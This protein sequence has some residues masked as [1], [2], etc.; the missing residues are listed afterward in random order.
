MFDTSFDV[1]I[2]VNI[3]I[4]KA[5]KGVIPLSNAFRKPRFC[6]HSARGYDL[7]D[8]GIPY[9]CDQIQGYALFY[10]RAQGI[11]YVTL[12]LLLSI[13]TAIGYD[14]N[15]VIFNKLNIKQQLI[16]QIARDKHLIPCT[17]GTGILPEGKTKVSSG[18]MMSAYQVRND[19]IADK[20]EQCITH[21]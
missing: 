12:S 2:D 10:M 11:E 20:L 14:L 17:V 9:V 18:R 16:K 5:K 15:E 3:D 4:K 1:D 13:A 7:R 8:L 6:T 19:L 21:C